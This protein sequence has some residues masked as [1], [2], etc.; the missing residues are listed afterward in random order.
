MIKKSGLHPNNPHK[1]GY[2]F[3]QLEKTSP[4]LTPHVFVNEYGTRTIDF[5]SPTAVKALNTALL[6]AVHKVQY[7]VFP[8]THLCPPIP[9][10]ADYIHYLNDLLEESKITGPVKVLDLGTGANCVYPLLGNRSYGWEF[11]GTDIDPKSLQVAK[12]IVQKNGLNIQ[13]SL[14][15]Q[16]DA[17]H[18]LEGVILKGEQFTVTMCN[19]PFYK[20]AAEAQGAN[21][22]KSRNLGTNTQ[23]NFSGNNNELWCVGGEKAFLH[24]YLYESSQYPTRSKWFT[25]L[26]SSKDT[27]KSLQVSAKKLGAKECRVIPMQQGNKV[28]RIVAWR[29]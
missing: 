28:T 15:L 18:V 8:D 29:F 10:R 14:R 3:Q 4:N 5:S 11:V 23:R 7:W 22:R 1:N 17:S 26:V 16:Q 6:L 21:A 20:S 12:T 25:S 13:V 9:G 24:T 2:D 19:P 27:V